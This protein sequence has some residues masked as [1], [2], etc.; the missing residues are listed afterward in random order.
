MV[1]Q[2]DR[3]VP[4]A[5]VEGVLTQQRKD[6][7]LLDG[8]ARIPF[9]A[10]DTTGRVARTGQPVHV[11]TR[12]TDADD[13]RRIALMGKPGEEFV[14]LAQRGDAD[15]R[16][17]AEC[18]RGHRHHG[19]QGGQACHDPMEGLPQFPCGRRSGTAA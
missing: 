13:T 12:G 11:D 2:A 17:I 16:G 3:L 15:A 7:Q 9:L 8:Q 10:P 5:G 6:A 19:R 14:H 1:G 4:P 18:R